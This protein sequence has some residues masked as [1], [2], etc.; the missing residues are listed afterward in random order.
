MKTSELLQLYGENQED[1]TRK[2]PSHTVQWLLTN[3]TDFISRMIGPPEKVDFR[4]NL[5]DF[6][7]AYHDISTD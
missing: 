4:L 5:D 7:R 6:A 1:G 3:P 2:I